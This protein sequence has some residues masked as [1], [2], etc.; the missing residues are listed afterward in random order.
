[1]RAFIK[2]Y[3]YYFYYISSSSC[4]YVCVF[5]IIIRRLLCA[6]YFPSLSVYLSV[7]QT[8][9]IV[10]GFVSFF[11]HC[12][13]CFRAVAIDGVLMMTMMKILVD[14]YLFIV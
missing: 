11:F 6:L 13:C 10:D 3:Y 5:F 8:H 4:V 1:M 14:N 2:Y 7:S 9:Y 12:C